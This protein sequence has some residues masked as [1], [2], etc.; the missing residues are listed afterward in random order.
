[1]QE[2]LAAWHLG[3]NY[4][5][6][7]YAVQL[8]EMVEN[9]WWREVLLLAAGYLAETRS[10]DA[11]RFLQK[12]APRGL[13]D[14]QPGKALIALALAGRALIQLRARFSQP[15]W[16]GTVAQAFAN[17]LYRLLYAEPVDAPIAARHEAGLVLGRLYGMP[18]DETGV[19]DPRFS[20]PQGLPDFVEIPAGDFWMGSDDSDEDDGRPR[21]R[22]VLSAY[23]VAKYPTTNA[24]YK[25]FIEADGYADA[26]WWAEAIKDGYWKEGKVQDY[27]TESWHHLPRY[28][29]DDR[30][31]NPSQPV[32]GVNWY[33][34]VAYCRW[35][36]AALGDGDVYRLPTEAEW[37]RA[38]RGP[39]GWAYP[40]GDAWQKGMCNSK[41]VGLEQTSP[42]GLFPEG[43]TREGLH[44]MVGNVDEWCRDWYAEDAYAASQR[45]NPTG[46]DSGR[47]RVLRG[48]SW[49]DDGPSI[50][51]CGFRYR[52]Y[53]RSGGNVRG[54]RCVRTLS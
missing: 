25:R 53:P 20:G 21:H 45:R 51:R 43:V 23:E 36:T 11:Y 13:E 19:G 18:G 31:N 40:W 30:W 29:D 32:V 52:V 9:P 42:V 2:F 16:Y 28:W 27:W 14:K 44:D 22:V 33:E 12:L 46:P 35:L 54:F 50:C 37:E 39:E 5:Y 10:S 7:D 15:S 26:R 38:A 4:R 6:P 49:Y 24:M 48:G 34:A 41:D 8:L 47:S 1:M 3:D 17:R